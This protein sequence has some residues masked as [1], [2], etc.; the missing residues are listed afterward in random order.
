MV[1]IL[2]SLLS[3]LAVAAKNV[4][5]RKLSFHT[6]NSVILYAKYLF[7]SVCAVLLLLVTGLPEIKPAFYYY[8]S[9]AS[10]IDVVASWY[11]IRAI[12][13]AQIAR[14]FPLVALT[15]IFLIVTSF[16]FLGEVPS[17]VGAGG[18]LAVVCGAYMLRSESIKVGPLEPFRLLLK[19]KAPRNMLIAAFLFSFLAVFFKKTILTSSPFFA[20]CITQLLGTLIVSALFIKTKSLSTVYRKIGND[21]LLLFLSGLAAFCAGLALFAAFKLGLASYVVSVK[22]T[23]ILFTAVLGYVCF[24]EDN[25]IRSLLIGVIMVV[26]IFLISI[27]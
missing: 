2:L 10:F 20:L 21:F 6:E 11:F 1:W 25:I 9:L 17:I 19:E 5:T 8:V 4:I 24:K 27:G 12:A 13:S 22:R 15:P 3:A 16:F 7:A 14:T 23:S 26:G 18:I